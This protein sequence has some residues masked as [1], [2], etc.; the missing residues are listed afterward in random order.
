ME[1][2]EVKKEAPQKMSYEELER[3]ASQLG[4]QARQLYSQLQNA[5]MSNMFKRLD[6]LF[7]VV[8]FA[9]VFNEEFYAKCAEEIEQIMTIPEAEENKEEQD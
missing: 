2:K 7:K 8:E 4:E 3:V 6:Y 9:H 5:N 1:E